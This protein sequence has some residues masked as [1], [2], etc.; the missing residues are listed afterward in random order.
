[1][2][3]LNLKSHPHDTFEDDHSKPQLTRLAQHDLFK[4]ELSESERRILT[5]RPGILEF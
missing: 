5:D 2:L 1:M 4:S 3:R